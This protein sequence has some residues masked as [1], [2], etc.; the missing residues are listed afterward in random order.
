[1]LAKYWMTRFVFTVFPAPDSP[2]EARGTHQN[3]GFPL[4]SIQSSTLPSPLSG[5]GHLHS[6]SAPS[7]LQNLPH[8]WSLWHSFQSPAPHTPCNHSLKPFLPPVPPGINLPLPQAP[9]WWA[10]AHSR[11]EDGLVLPIWK[12]KEERQWGRGCG[13]RS[14]AVGLRGH[15]SGPLGSPVSIY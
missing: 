12:R 1:M 7:S 6:S 8:H 13:S 5:P 11:D 15:R 2:L 10:A 14:M 4:F 9:L 3:P